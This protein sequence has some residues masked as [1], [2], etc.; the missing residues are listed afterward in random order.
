MVDI[1]CQCYNMIVSQ[2]IL[3]RPPT[4]Y[5][6]WQRMPSK[7]NKDPPMHLTPA[8]QTPETIYV[9]RKIFSAMTLQGMLKLAENF[10]LSLP[11]FYTE[12]YTVICDDKMVTLS[13]SVPDPLG[14]WTDDILG[15][16]M[17]HKNW[18]SCDSTRKSDAPNVCINACSTRKDSYFPVP[19]NIGQS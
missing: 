15:W 3:N 13:P 17:S 8:I 12:D 10:N 2:R 5:I 19:E 6:K 11:L 9:C 16:A 4:R 1:S 7:C 18:I 14:G